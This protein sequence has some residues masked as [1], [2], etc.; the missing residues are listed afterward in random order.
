MLTSTTERNA[1]A[2][3][4]KALLETIQVGETV[5]FD[6]LSDA[7]GRG[8]RQSMYL[9]Y[10]AAKDLNGEIGAV[11]ASVRG[12]GYKR[13]PGDALASV[14]E[15]ARRRIRRSAKG[16]TRT[17]TN[18]ARRANDLSPEQTRRIN[19]ELSVLGLA[20]HVAGSGFVK[21]VEETKPDAPMPTAHVARAFLAHITR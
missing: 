7:I 6:A 16:A 3:A 10:A 20:A 2:R 12:V 17:I 11:F 1:D 9:F 5:T 13:L 4:I 14:G 18:A 19:A 21:Q 15:T 8:I